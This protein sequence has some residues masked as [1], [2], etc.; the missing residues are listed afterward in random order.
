MPRKETRRA[1]F[2]A[3]AGVVVDDVEQHLD[4]GGVQVGN[5]RAE[6]AE[7]VAADESVVRAEEVYRAVAPVIAQALADQVLLVGDRMDRQQLDGGDAQF[8]QVVDHR[9]RTEAGEGAALRFRYFRMQLG[10]ALDVQFVDHRLRPRRVRQPLGSP[11][12]PG[13]D[14]PAFRHEPGAVA[15]VQRQVAAAVRRAGSRNARR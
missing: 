6:F 12:E 11:G 2:V 3:L 15:L 4:A 9:R 1:E 5:H 7:P 13:L 14:D 8:H 10:V